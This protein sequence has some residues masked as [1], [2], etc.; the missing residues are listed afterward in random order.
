MTTAELRKATRR[1]DRPLAM[2]RASRPLTPSERAEYRRALKG[3]RAK[4]DRN[5]KR[6]SITVRPDLLKRADAYA[7]RQRMTR[8]Q[9]I[10]RGLET[11]IGSAA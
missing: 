4:N 3:A 10:A 8:S 9:L 7:K 1:Y 6:V 5:A 2:E 11:M